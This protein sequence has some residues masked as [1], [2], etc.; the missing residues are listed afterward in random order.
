MTNQERTYSENKI[1]VAVDLGSTTIGVCCVNLKDKKEI[2]SFSFSNP[3]RIY[4]A[5]IITRIKHC[6]DN[7]FMVKKMHL[8]IEEALQLHLKEY[9]ED[10]YSHICSIVYSGNTTM[11]HI[12]QEFSLNGLSR[13]PFQPVDLNYK[14][15]IC[16]EIPCIF[17][18]GFSAFAG[19]D[20]LAGAEY[21]Q[22]GKMDAYELLIDLGT[23]GELLLLN[24]KEGFV[25]STA[26]GPVFDNVISGAKYGSEVIKTISL[27]VKRGLIDRTGKLAD[28]LFEKG[29]FI[30]RNIILK[31]ENIRNFQLAKGAVYAGIRCLMDKAGITSKDVVRVFISGGLGFYMNPRDAF[32][33]KMLPIEFADKIEISGNTSLEGAKRILLE[34]DNKTQL[35]K[36][37]DKLRKRT[38]SFELANAEH[39]QQ[40]YLNSLEF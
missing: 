37:Y 24:K 22:M 34:E 36:E 17:L 14:E 19:A 4:G 26:C 38:E 39:F 7:P 2:L 20:I 32:T 16:H 21:L 3:Q 11:L 25:S 33:L 6:I 23:N 10:A 18:P 9:L 30:D 40:Y 5:D 13:A 35:L 31:Q 27:C 15:E 12:M 29:I 1:G 28:V 8:L